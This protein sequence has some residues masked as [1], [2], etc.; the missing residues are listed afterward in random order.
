MIVA[1]HLSNNSFS[2]VVV[3]K[4]QTDDEDIKNELAAANSLCGWSMS[5]T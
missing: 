4:A 5:F 3:V 2:R 1:S